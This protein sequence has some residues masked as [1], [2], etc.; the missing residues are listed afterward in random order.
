MFPCKQCGACCRNL[1]LSSL[2]S[3]LDRGDGTCKYLNGNLCSRYDTRP[4][5]CRVDDCYTLFF[6]DVMSIEQYYERNL[7]MCKALQKKMKQ[8]D[9]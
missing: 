2:Y 1:Q 3:E 8:E 9:Q 7:S 6:K 4:L 5:L